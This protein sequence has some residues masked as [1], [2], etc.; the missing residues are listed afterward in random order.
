MATNPPTAGFI[1]SLD[2]SNPIDS[3]K[4]FG[5]NDWMQFLQ[6]V[7]KTNQFPI[8]E[9]GSANGWDIAL[10]VKA[11]E[12]NSLL[13]IDPAQTVEARFQSLEADAAKLPAGT[14]MVFCQLSLPSGWKV[15]TDGD[16][17]NRMLYVRQN[18]QGGA[19]GGNDSPIFNEYVSSHYHIIQL[20]AGG[21]HDHPIYGEGDT[22][23]TVG[24]FQY[25]PFSTKGTN[26]VPHETGVSTAVIV[27]DSGEHTHVGLAD[28]I[29][30]PATEGNW[31][32][33]F[34]Q[35]IMGEKE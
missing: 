10:T 33:K 30:G 23:T 31:Q 26:P 34:V 12:V 6:D 21:G 8:S 9:D 3:N 27:P 5:G 35:V 16:R 2:P 24:V 14:V 25:L 15:P 28:L 4:V 22:G 13:G 11:S 18:G 17:A 1:N 20:A 7:V 19:E 29:G 32:P